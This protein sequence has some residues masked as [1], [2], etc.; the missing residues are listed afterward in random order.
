MLIDTKAYR[1]ACHNYKYIILSDVKEAERAWA[2]WSLAT[3]ETNK[4]KIGQCTPKVL[5]DLTWC[6]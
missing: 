1:V 4:T 5:M 3:L 6:D 2:S